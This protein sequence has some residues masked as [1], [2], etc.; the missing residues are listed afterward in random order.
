MFKNEN[1]N[2]TNKHRYFLELSFIG[3]NR[4]FVLVYS[5]QDDNIKIYKVFD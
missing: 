4:L 3:V 1:K 5:N 2:I